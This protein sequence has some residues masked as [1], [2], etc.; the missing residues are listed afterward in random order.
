LI[1]IYTWEKKRLLSQWLRHIFAEN[2]MMYD[3]SV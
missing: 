3:S 1:C 2:A